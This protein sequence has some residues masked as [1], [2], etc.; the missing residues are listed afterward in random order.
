MLPRRAHNII[1]ASSANEWASVSAVTGK[2]RR[3]IAV[4][5]RTAGRTALAAGGLAVVLTVAIVA[6]HFGQ[7]SG[8][9]EVLRPATVPPA[10][11]LCTQQLS[12]AADGNASPLFCPSGEINRLAWKYFADLNLL[13]MA[14]G[15]NAKS[16]D[17]EAAVASDL[18]GSTGPI[19]CSAYQLAAVYYGWT[20]GSDPT[21][22]VLTGG[23]PIQ[24]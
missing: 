10:V 19:E 22:S 21:R 18:N 15:P 4:N 2:K 1:V 17:V 7:E 13:V 23:C 3:V 12:Y 20:F 11:G 24:R 14:L 9:A 8:G 5:R 6:F 16:S